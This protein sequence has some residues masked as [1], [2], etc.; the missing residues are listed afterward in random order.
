MCVGCRK[1]HVG[2]S[3]VRPTTLYSI[4]NAFNAHGT[5]VWRLHPLP[6]RLWS[7]QGSKLCARHCS[8]TH[9]T[10][11]SNLRLPTNRK[12][13]SNKI[14]KTTI[15]NRR[16]QNVCHFLF[17]QIDFPGSQFKSKWFD[18]VKFPVRVTGLYMFCARHARCTAAGTSLTSCLELLFLTK[19]EPR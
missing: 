4:S 6:Y 2:G 16:N 10:L 9:I 11:N 18:S 8:Y 3:H 17:L 7:V 5:T 15:Q 14:R 19:Q 1:D 12:E 13:N